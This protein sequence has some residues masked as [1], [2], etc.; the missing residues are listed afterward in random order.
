MEISIPEKIVLILRGDL[1]TPRGSF[2]YEGTMCEILPTYSYSGPH[3]GI[4]DY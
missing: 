4:I 2:A 3:V 1:G